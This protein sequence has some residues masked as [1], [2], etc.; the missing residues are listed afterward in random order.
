MS[1][2]QILL[3]IVWCMGFFACLLTG[4][5]NYLWPTSIWNGSK[6]EYLL[7]RESNARVVLLSPIWFIWILIGVIWMLVRLSQGLYTMFLS[8]IGKERE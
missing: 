2:T 4:L 1:N 5:F 6:E 8:A 7:M 3:A